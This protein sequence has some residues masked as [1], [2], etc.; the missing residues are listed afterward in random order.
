[1][2][3][4]TT[5]IIDCLVYEPNLFEDKR[6]IFSEL[7]KTTTHNVNIKQINYSYSHTGVVRGLHR[8]PYAKLVT[9]VKGKV[10]DVCLDLRES[11]PTYKQWFGIDLSET[12]LNQLYIPPYCAHGFY[13]YE[14]SILIYGQTDVYNKE[15]DETYCFSD[16]G[17]KWPVDG[18][19]IISDKDSCN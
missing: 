13:A 6:G 2:K 10:F 3:I 16:F 8:T 1:M 7:Y 17:V 4:Q 5:K 15:Q 19:Y 12:N 11:S 18:P 14:S 9:C